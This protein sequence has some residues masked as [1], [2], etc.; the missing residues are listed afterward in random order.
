MSHA[1]LGC[2]PRAALPLP[3]LIRYILFIY[4]NILLRMRA[5]VRGACIKAWSVPELALTHGAWAL[6]LTRA[7]CLCRPGSGRGPW[8]IPGTAALAVTTR[9]GIQ[10]QIELDKQKTMSD[11]EDPG[12]GRNFFSFKNTTLWRRERGGQDQTQ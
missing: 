4:R 8:Y 5:I 9:H 2:D 7:L 6:T 10:T 12:K 11:T 1:A 3:L